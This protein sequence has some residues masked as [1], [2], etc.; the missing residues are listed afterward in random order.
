MHPNVL[1]EMSDRRLE[2]YHRRAEHARRVAAVRRAS[3]APHR[4]GPVRARAG[5]LLVAMR[6]ALA[7]TRV[8]E[9][10]A[11]RRSATRAEALAIG[12]G[13]D[14]VRPPRTR[15]HQSSMRPPSPT[16]LALASGAGQT[17]QLRG[18]R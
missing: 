16:G 6:T 1:A 9:R 5:A 7:G 14:I 4:A 8:F 15:E 11:S 3:G 17:A 13:C 2:D 18:A 12:L 10:N